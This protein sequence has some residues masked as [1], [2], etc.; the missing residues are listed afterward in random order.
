MKMQTN[1]KGRLNNT[2]LPQTSALLPLFEAVVNS[3]HGIEEAGLTSGQGRITVKIDREQVSEPL[4]FGEVKG[5]R[6]PK[7]QGEIR[8]F[9]IQDN[10]VGFNAVNFDAFNELDTGHKA[11][12]GC[13]G[14]GRLLWLKAFESVAVRSVYDVGGGTAWS[15]SF[16]F[17]AG[18]GVH[19]TQNPKETADLEAQ[20]DVTLK[21]FRQQYRKNAKKT[22]EAIANALLE[23]CLWYYVRDGGAPN[24][25]VIDGDDT[26]DLDSLYEERM[27]GSAKEELATLK[28]EQFRL[29][30]VRMRHAATSDPIAA[31]CADNRLV[32]EVKLVGKIPGMHGKLADETGDF[33]Y[34]CYVSSSVLDQAVR[35]ERHGFD[36]PDEP[37]SVYG[38][39]DMSLADVNQLIIR[40]AAAHLAPYLVVAREQ[41]KKRI[42]EFVSKAPKY[43]PI[44]ARMSNEELA[45]DPAST[46]RD[47]DMLLHRRVYEL[48]SVALAD[49]HEIVK[50]GP[51]ESHVEYRLRLAKY[52]ES[53]QDLKTIDLASYVSHRKVIIDLLQAAVEVRGDGK[54]AKEAMIHDLIMPMRT[55]ADEVPF[56][57]WNLWLVDERLA[58]HDYLQSDKSLASAPI[59]GSD[60]GKEPDIFALQVYDNPVLVSDSNAPKLAKIVI[61]EI[62]RPMR[63]DASEGDNPIEQALGYLARVREGKVLT[64]QG[65]EIPHCEDIPGYCYVLAD[66]TP[67]MRKR[68]VYASLRENAEHTGYFGYNVELKAFVEVISFDQLVTAARERNRAFFDKLGLPTD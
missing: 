68:C 67:T 7:P 61:V 36:L 31:Y 29:L 34:H 25:Q 30:H 50:P 43:R 11:G 57:S 32:T 3:I 51:A 46:D 23:H 26:I 12:K 48:E 17:D 9:H 65:R 16:V 45:V 62:K 60:S 4:D 27:H 8:D 15:R 53:L 22:A 64:R 38:D 54:Y 33:V 10:G 41:G 13:R 49:G 47:L 59:T 44:V 40:R 19:T 20:T 18:R 58:F 5:R 66:L 42:E 28:G 14:I 63:N 6:G 21:G 56:S 24:I 39:H 55:V 35:S 2:S 1:L 37:L 52:L